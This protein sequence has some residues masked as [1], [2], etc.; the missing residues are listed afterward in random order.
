MLLPTLP[1]AA[2]QQ[3][4]D[5]VLVDTAG[6]MQDNEPLMRA[7]AKVGPPHP[8]TMLEIPSSSSLL[9]P[10]PHSS[11]I[12]SSPSLLPHSLLT[13]TPPSFPPH[14]HSSLIPSSPS[15]LPHSL[16]TL[17]SPSFPHP[18][19]SLIPPSPSL[20]PHSLLTADPCQQP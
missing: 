20:L 5:V 12:P 13:L 6:R 18:H 4:Y 2:R 14:P 3:R 7:L 17:T 10:H 1:H 16:L 19:F 11:L 15:L 8:L 9:P